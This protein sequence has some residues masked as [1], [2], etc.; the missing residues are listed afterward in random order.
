MGT[1]P[2]SPP[3]PT[4]NSGLTLNWTQPT[5]NSDGT[6][7]ASGELAGYKI[8]FGSSATQ[9]DQNVAITDPTVT[10]YTFQNLPSGTWYFALISI[11][12]A[13]NESAPTNV[14][15]ATI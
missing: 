15:S 3:T 13:G 9:L 11:D 7:I 14:V 5:E 8:V 2:S 12:S 1:A 6:P 4:Q 10:T